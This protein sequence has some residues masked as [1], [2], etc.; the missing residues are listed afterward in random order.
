MFVDP[1]LHTFINHGCAGSNNV[2]H[3]LTITEEN[4]NPKKIP[5]EI[6]E[7]NLAGVVYNPAAARQSHFYSS[8]S[9]LRDITKGEELLDNYLGMTGINIKG[10]S[11]D[12]EGLKQQCAGGTGSITEYERAYL[13]K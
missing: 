9:P 7:D 1:T 13:Y 8:A 11:E 5:P 4:A 12:V 6:L 3:N 2:G 10:W